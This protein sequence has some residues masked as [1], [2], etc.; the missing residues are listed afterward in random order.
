M[1]NF[2]NSDVGSEVSSHFWWAGSTIFTDF[3][4]GHDGFNYI[5][6]TFKVQVRCKMLTVHQ[7]TNFNIFSKISE[8]KCAQKGTKI[9]RKW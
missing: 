3:T 6:G 4:N 5:D 8:E 9:C 2:T 1:D 7:F